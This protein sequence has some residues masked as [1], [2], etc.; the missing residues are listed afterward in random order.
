MEVSDG[1]AEARR[2]NVL[3][4]G[5]LVIS[6]ISASFAGWQACETRQQTHS[7]LRAYVGILDSTIEPM[8]LGQ[9]LQVRFDVKNSGQTI[10]S[11]ADISFVC[12]IRSREP[13]ISQAPNSTTTKPESFVIL[14][15]NAVKFFCKT[16]GS[17]N[18][19][20]LVMTGTVALTG[21]ITYS[22]IFKEVHQTRFCYENTADGT[23]L[24]QCKSGNEA[25]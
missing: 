15:G 22:D 13:Q 16:N 7:S 14:P 3:S 4:T 17:A 12:A 10:A 20:E 19:K 2:A 5:A 11:Y 21:T 6:L 8:T 18:E 9:P 25:E 1:G 23:E 24:Q